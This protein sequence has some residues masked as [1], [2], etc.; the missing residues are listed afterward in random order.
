M[1]QNGFSIEKELTDFKN[2]WSLLVLRAGDSLAVV[3]VVYSRW[4]LP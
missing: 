1:V 4:V 3:L 2:R